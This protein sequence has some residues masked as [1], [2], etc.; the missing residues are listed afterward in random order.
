[1]KCSPWLVCCSLL[2]VSW[3]RAEEKTAYVNLQPKANQ[4]LTDNLGSGREGNNLPLLKGEQTLGEVKFKIEEGFL[5]LGSKLQAAPKPAKVEGI[6]VNAKFSKL[7]ILHA[8]GYGNGSKIHEEGMLG[9]PLFV[10]DMTTIAQYKVNYEDGSSEDIAVVYGE[11]VRDWFYTEKSKDV[12][13]GK[14]AWRGGNGLTEQLGCKVRLYA[15]TWENP[16]PTKQVA[17]IDFLKTG[18]TPAAPFCVA[19]TMVVP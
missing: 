14:I 16:H 7:H 11:D 15:S 4:K 17:S 9:D 10:P 3:V 12:T 8:T 6:E 2:L 13:R 18:D 19:M 1:M 5:Q